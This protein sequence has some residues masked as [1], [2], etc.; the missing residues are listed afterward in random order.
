MINAIIGSAIGT[1]ITLG[2][3]YAYV[4]YSRKREYDKR[5]K[6]FH[7]IIEKPIIFDIKV[8]NEV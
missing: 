6:I 5:K 7:E 2:L 8:E 1:I 4:E 3:L